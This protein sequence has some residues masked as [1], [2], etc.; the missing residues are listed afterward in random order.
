VAKPAT[1]SADVNPAAEVAANA[2]APTAEVAPATAAEV[3]AAT[4]AEVAAA[5]A[6]EVAAAPPT[7]SSV[8]TAGE[9]G[10]RREH[11]QSGRER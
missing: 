7:T 2:A 4:A 3:A 5:A 11:R 6:A 1:Q 10:C 8:T 9:R